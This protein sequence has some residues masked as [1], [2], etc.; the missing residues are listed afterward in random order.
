MRQNTTRGGVTASRT[1]TRRGTPVVDL[2][3]RR[4]A[5]L[6]GASVAETTSVTGEAGVLVEDD[7]DELDASNSGGDEEGKG[8]VTSE[9]EAYDKF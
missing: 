1:V 9:E 5:V 6:A 3:T 2:R 8:S 7:E 4:A